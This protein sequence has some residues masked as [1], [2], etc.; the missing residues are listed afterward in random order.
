[1]P[2]N[3]TIDGIAKQIKNK[4]GKIKP[5]CEN[6]CRL[7]GVRHCGIRSGDGYICTRVFKHDGDHAACYRFKCGVAIWER[8]G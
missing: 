3:K 1:M 2:N 6:K 4:R 5:L 8:E 7:E